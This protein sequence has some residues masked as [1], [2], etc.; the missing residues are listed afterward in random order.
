MVYLIGGGIVQRLV[1]P[2]A[3]VAVNVL[4]DGAAQS[5]GI[6]VLIDVDSFCF[7]AAEPALDHDVIR[8]AGLAIHALTDVE[9]FQKVLVLG[10]GELTA[11]IRVGDSRGAVELHGIPYRPDDGT[12]V[13]SVGEVPAH[14]LPAEPVDESGEVH[15]AMLHPDVGDVDG[16]NLIW[17]LNADISQQIRHN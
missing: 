14:N 7:Q 6:V 10:A 5:P 9:V 1:G 8:P 16:P 4:P 17:E 2:E 3:I 11:L 13:Q 15:V 12:G